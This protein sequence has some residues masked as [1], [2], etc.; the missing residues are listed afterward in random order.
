VLVRTATAPV[1]GKETRFVVLAVRDRG[2]GVAPAW[3]ERIFEVFQRGAEVQGER[4]DADARR[5]A[6]VG[7]AA[8]RAI[9]RAHGGDMRVRAR[10][11]GGASFECW[12]PEASEPQP[13]PAAA[14]SADLS[15]DPAAEQAAT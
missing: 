4:P 6:G 10:S 1:A 14:S 13:E 7:L 9:A 3:R 15:A 8:C 2:P 12:L 5:G 11:H